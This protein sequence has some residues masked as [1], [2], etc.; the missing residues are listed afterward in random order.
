MLIS[1]DRKKDTLFVLDN[2]TVL[3]DCSKGDS[4]YLCY[5][6]SEGFLGGIK[7]ISKIIDSSIISK[8]TT[9]KMCT[10]INNHV[11][12]T[13]VID[14]V[15]GVHEL[16]LFD[17]RRA[18]PII[19]AYNNM[20][21]V[22]EP[23]SYRVQVSNNSYG[24]PEGIPVNFDAMFKTFDEAYTYYKSVS[25]KTT[26]NVKISAINADKDIEVLCITM[27]KVSGF[28]TLYKNIV[29]HYSLE[30]EQIKRIL[31]GISE[32]TSSR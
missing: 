29:T 26:L 27:Y 20:V 4:F 21:D 10:L 5:D 13:A 22:L 11:V 7:E 31:S 15:N 17:I 9:V 32:F 1:I 12:T 23:T 14:K 28:S 16:K 8:Y 30:N 19:L 25:N 18:H 2:N 24:V 3:I 6:A